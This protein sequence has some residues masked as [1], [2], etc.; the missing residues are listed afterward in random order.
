MPRLSIG[1]RLDIWFSE[2]FLL[3]TRENLRVL[4][5]KATVK[6][7]YVSNFFIRNPDIQIQNTLKLCLD[8]VRAGQELALQKPFL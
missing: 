5:A 6:I 3:T 2:F 7:I 8:L 4:V 1:V